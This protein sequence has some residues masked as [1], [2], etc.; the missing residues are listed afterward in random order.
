[1]ARMRRFGRAQGLILA[2]CAGW[3]VTP[4][5]IGAPVQPAVGVDILCM[6]Y[7]RSLGPIFTVGFGESFEDAALLRRVDLPLLV[8]GF[9]IDVTR[10]LLDQVRRTRL[11]NATSVPGWADAI[12]ATF[13]A[14]RRQFDQG[15]EDRRR[16]PVNQR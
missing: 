6:L 10:L 11:A 8:D 15:A 7:R 3:C 1:M 16:F 5:G 14:I 13:H 9:E 12:V 2:L 4:A